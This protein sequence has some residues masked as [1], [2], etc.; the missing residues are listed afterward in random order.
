MA[1]R[2]K[3]RVEIDRYA[4]GQINILANK[5][6]TK[7]SEAYQKNFD[8]GIMEWRVLAILAVYEN[9]SV[10]NITDIIGLDKGAVSRALKKLEAKSYVTIQ[11]DEFNKRAYIIN[12]TKQGRLLH[13]KVYDFSMKRE[14]K[15][16]S[17]LNHDEKEELFKYLKYLKEMIDLL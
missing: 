14:E 6:A 9:Y 11:E 17:K 1:D 12:I 7:S 10:Q 5:L 16:L 8:I 2:S 3:K 4:I 15:L 13:D